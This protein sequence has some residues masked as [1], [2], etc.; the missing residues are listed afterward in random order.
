MPSSK[1]SDLTPAASLVLTDLLYVLVDPAGTPLDRKATLQQLVT[2]VQAAIVDGSPATLDTLNELAAAL[3]DDANYA[4][5]I[6]SALAGKQPLDADLTAIAA[7]TTTAFGRSLLEAATAA[8]AR[9]TL[10][11][12]V[13][14]LARTV[15]GAGGAA[16][17]DLASIPAT[18]ENLRL[19]FYGRAD[20]ASDERQLWLRIN[21]DSGANY[22]TKG[23]ESAGS[24]SLLQSYGQTRAYLGRIASANAGAGRGSFMEAS[25]GGYARTTFTKMLHSMCHYFGVSDSWMSGTNHWNSTAAINQLTLL[26]S[27]GNFV[28]GSVATLYGIRGE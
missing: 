26:P 11:V 25:F 20:V 28:E 8:A 9:S 13:E 7:L 15:V 16:S 1:L 4:A 23:A 18:Y 3:G 14:V 22:H 21:N 10:G 24:L 5:T 19:T 2:L 12:A 27:S 17:I 6:T